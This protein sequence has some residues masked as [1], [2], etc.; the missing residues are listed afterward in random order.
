VVSRPCL[1]PCRGV[2]DVRDDLDGAGAGCRGPCGLRVLRRAR[3]ARHGPPAEYGLASGHS[4]APRAWTRPSGVM[5]DDRVSA[6]GRLGGRRC[7]AHTGLS[8]IQAAHARRPTTAKAWDL[9]EHAPDRG[10]GLL[11]NVIHKRLELPSMRP[12]GNVG[13]WSELSQ[14]DE[15]LGRGPKGVPVGNL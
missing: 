13:G 2:P 6:H 7:A 8:P 12:Q 4:P 10:V 14:I 5:L 15:R 11:S 9:L 3:H 1:F